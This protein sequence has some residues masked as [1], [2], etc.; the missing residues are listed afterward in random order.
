MFVR[1]YLYIYIY[2]LYTYDL[3]DIYT[4]IHSLRSTHTLGSSGLLFGRLHPYNPCTSTEKNALPSVSIVGFGVGVASLLVNHNN[5]GDYRYW[6]DWHAAP[7]RMLVQED[8][9]Q[10]P[11][12][13]NEGSCRWAYAGLFSKALLS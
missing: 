6:R 8:L 4:D 11:W 9:L 7:P 13:R 2:A 10:Q 5:N 1:V 12:H 3:Y